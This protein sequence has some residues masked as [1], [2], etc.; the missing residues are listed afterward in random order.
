MKSDVKELLIKIVTK[1]DNDDH[2]ILKDAK[3]IIAKYQIE[4]PKNKPKSETK[5]VEKQS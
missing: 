3:N 2:G 5:N 4:I 1:L